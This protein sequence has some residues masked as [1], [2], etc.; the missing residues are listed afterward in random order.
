MSLLLDARKKAQQALSAQGSHN[1]LELSLEEFPD[2]SSPADTQPMAHARSAG[3][4][5]FDAK[6]HTPS[7]ARAGINRNLLIA[8]GGTIILLAAGAG[9]VWYAISVDTQP[10][11]TSHPQSTPIAQP[12]PANTAP[13]PVNR[14]GEAAHDKVTPAAPTVAPRKTR[15]T[16]ASS[17]KSSAQTRKKSP[18]RIEQHQVEPIDPLLN[19]AYQA[20]LAGNFDLAQQLYLKVLRLDARNTDALLGLAAIAQRQGA[21]N[22]AAHY[23]AQVLE[24]DPRDAVANAGMSALTTGGNSE[25]RIKNLL[26][27]QQDSSSLHFALGNRYAEQARWGEAQQSYFNAYKLKPDNAQLAFNLAVS[28]DQLGKKDLAAQYYQRALELDSKSS[29]GFDHAQ[30]SQR[31]EELTH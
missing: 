6:T 19:D 4:N 28:L 23:Y 30:I 31:I 16:S 22:I 10:M 26:N 12:A 29:S 2:T 11:R 15:A 17:R 21:D 14:V 18:M 9:Y 20:Y 24:L 13:P 5:L 7:H 1:G 25:S 3:Q 8:L 27:E